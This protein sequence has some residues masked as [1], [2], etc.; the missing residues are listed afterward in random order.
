MIRNPS[1]FA[2]RRTEVVVRI[3]AT[4]DGSS[5]W[6]PA[7]SKSGFRFQIAPVAQDR[8]DI[9]KLHRALR[10]H[11]LSDHPVVAV[12][13]GVLVIDQWDE[14]RRIRRTTFVVDAARDI[15]L[16]PSVERR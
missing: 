1:A 10:E 7:C 14:I 13:R 11:G 5:V 15:R 12:L 3:T 16:S 4:K 6:D 8:P 2:N 9:L